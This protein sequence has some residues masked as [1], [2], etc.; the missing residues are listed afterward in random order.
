M[1]L[2][3][4]VVLVL[5]GVLFDLLGVLLLCCV[6][7]FSSGVFNYGSLVTLG[8]ISGPLLGFVIFIWGSYWCL[9][10]NFW[11][12]TYCGFLDGHFDG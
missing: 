4:V 10:P 5:C 8:R 3:C 1:L 11:C 6:V 7:V 12:I 2:R 9:L